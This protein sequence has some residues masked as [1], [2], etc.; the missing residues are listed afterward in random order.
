[1]TAFDDD[2]PEFIP[3]FVHPR[4]RPRAPYIPPELVELREL[5]SEWGDFVAQKGRVDELADKDSLTFGEQIEARG[6]IRATKK[7]ADD[8]T[9]RAAEAKRQGVDWPDE[10]I[11][12][13]IVELTQRD[14]D[15]AQLRNRSGWG[16]AH[17]S[18]GHFCFAMLKRDRALALKVG[19]TIVG[20]F[21]QQMGDQA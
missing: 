2:L 16:A 18:T 15:R 10:R 5:R 13:Y 17:S 6:L 11:E 7:K 21:T 12:R 4:S 20:H 1:M 9:A 19:R 3:D 8:R 14:Q